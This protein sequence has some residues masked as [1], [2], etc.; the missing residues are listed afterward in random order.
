M[1]RAGCVGAAAFWVFPERP[2]GT[3]FREPLCWCQ[4][5]GC[6]AITHDTR[7]AAHHS[8]K[9]VPRDLGRHDDPVAD[10]EPLLFSGPTLSEAA[11][12]NR[13]DAIPLAWRR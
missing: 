7:L 3:L 9:A 5:C 13:H 2:S 4:M 12:R 6:S 11:L 1:C 10:F 8:V